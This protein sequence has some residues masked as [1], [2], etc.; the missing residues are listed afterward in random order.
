MFYFFA[1]EKFIY[2]G[3]TDKLTWRIQNF[4]L[5]L[6]TPFTSAKPFLATKADF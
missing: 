1:I 2:A 6:G 5:N 3:F 4:I